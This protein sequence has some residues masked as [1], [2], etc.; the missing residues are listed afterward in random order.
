M[1]PKCVLI[2]GC[3]DGGIGSALV[4]EFHRQGLHIYVSARSKAQ[5]AH[6]KS[7][8][9]VTFLKMDV[10]SL[11]EIE[12]AARF[13]RDHEGQLDILINN[14]GQSM[15]YPALDSSIEESK[16]L[17]DVNVFGPMA[18]TQAFAPLVIAARGTIVNVCSISGVANAPWMSK[19]D[20]FFQR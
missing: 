2:T 4:S 13:V 16:K 10:T 15:V 5:L 18:V 12:E 17:F 7:L 14:A 20:L 8:P 19:F 1:L 9:N 6:F 3:S 11:S